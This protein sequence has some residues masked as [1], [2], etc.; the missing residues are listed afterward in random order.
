MTYYA[1]DRDDDVLGRPHDPGRGA[2]VAKWIV[3]IALAIIM[4]NIAIAA[5][6]G[7]KKAAQPAPSPTPVVT[8]RP[9]VP[10]PTSS[11][12][13]AARD[14]SSVL[15]VLPLPTPGSPSP[16]PAYPIALGALTPAGDVVL[17]DSDT[18]R[19]M[20]V[21][22]N[23][24]DGAPV[25]DIS[26]DAARAIMY[27]DR[28]G[29]CP[30]VW[31]Y[32]LEFG[33]AELFAGGSHPVVSPDG[34]RVAVIGSGCRADGGKVDGVAIYSAADGTQ[35]Q[36]I[37]QG[38]G[39]TPA[40]VPGSAIVDVDW[41]PTQDAELVVTLSGDQYNQHRV[42]ELASPPAAIA[43]A[44]EL[45]MV[46][47]FD[48]EFYQLEYVDERLLLVG[49]CCLDDLR[50]KSRR[51]AVRNLGTGRVTSLAE[52]PVLSITADGRGGIRWLE[53]DPDAGGHLRAASLGTDRALGS[54]RDIGRGLFLRIDW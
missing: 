20:L 28:A 18:A 47:E 14:L 51:V 1:E 31:R 12:S 29:D 32:R 5:L 21:L 16:T 6:G 24:V 11:P 50:P 43:E 42:V 33:R 46:H 8:S 19:T 22:V 4:I 38:E 45:P 36:W 35:Q 30:T 48:E 10:A 3:I 49:S 37:P 23:A 52:T 44:A 27:F 25:R 54:G 26:W 13:A 39:G 34:R 40:V 7:P 53:D 41:V 15:P 2:R 17:I 9:T